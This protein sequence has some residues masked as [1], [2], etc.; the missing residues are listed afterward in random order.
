M[1]IKYTIQNIRKESIKDNPVKY[2]RV[3]G[4]SKWHTHRLEAELTVKLSNGRTVFFPEGFTWD[5]ASVPQV[6]HG[7]IRPE[8]EDNIAYLI[9]DYLYTTM[10]ESR[11]FADDEMLRWAKA[12]KQ[13]RRISLRNIDIHIRYFAVRAFG[14]IVWNKNKP[15]S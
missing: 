9:H 1:A 3:I 2:S 4:G 10:V 8:G 13:T 12:M 6:F 11:K 5:L 14:W 15:K 7:I